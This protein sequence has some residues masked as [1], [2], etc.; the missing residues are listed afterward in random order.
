[1]YTMAGIFKQTKHLDNLNF[2]NR[3]L[4]T[5]RRESRWV[6]IVY[7]VHHAHGVKKR[8]PLQL[9]LCCSV[10]DMCAY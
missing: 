9:K 10:I 8:F 4:T 6:A 5:H 2:V 3:H 7:A 1:M